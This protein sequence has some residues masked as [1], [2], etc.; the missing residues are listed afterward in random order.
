MRRVSKKRAAIDR[1]IKA[2]RD[3]YKAE[4]RT[5]ANCGGPGA[6]IHEM[7]GG[8]STRVKAVQEPACWLLLCRKCH[9]LFH[10]PSEW[11]L[12]RQAALKFLVDY[13][14]FSLEAVCRVMGRAP[15][16]LTM[17]DLLPHLDLLR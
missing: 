4:M 8:M 2:L 16:A 5:C 3:A 14:R 7:C 1:E 10:D 17:R 6:D 11:S 12:S 15:T 13:D 9:D